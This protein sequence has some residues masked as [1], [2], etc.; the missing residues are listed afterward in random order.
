LKKN[1]LII[2]QRKFSGV[3]P[4]A[5]TSKSH[6]NLFQNRQIFIQNR[7]NLRHK[8]TTNRL[9]LPIRMMSRDTIPT[10]PL[11]KDT[12]LIRTTSKSH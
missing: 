4:D 11:L 5:K 7:K 3:E 10:H 2:S 8:V 12:N 9:I 1:I 6:Q